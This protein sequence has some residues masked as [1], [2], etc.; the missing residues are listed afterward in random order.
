MKQ[1]PVLS[2]IV[3]VTIVLSFMAVTSSKSQKRSIRD[4]RN[5]LKHKSSLFQDDI[6]NDFEEIFTPSDE[7]IA[8]S[9]EIV[10]D[11]IF[12]R[13]PCVWKICK[14]LKKLKFQS[15]QNKKDAHK[16]L[17]KLIKFYS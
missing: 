13:F 8:N 4:F 3:I 5:H 14:P 10:K 11:L 6:L 2:I 9:E 15:N 16:I 12:D 7:E 1:F 17:A